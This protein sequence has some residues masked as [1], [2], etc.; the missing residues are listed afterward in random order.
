MQIATSSIFATAF[1]VFVPRFQKIKTEFLTL[2][3]LSEIDPNN[4][5]Q[6]AN[7]NINILGQP[8]SLSGDA[9]Y[10]GF[11]AYNNRPYSLMMGWP[12]N[13]SF[14]RCVL[15][16]CSSP[17]NYSKSKFQKNFCWKLRLVEIIGTKQKNSAFTNTI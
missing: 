8:H 15:I 3:R 6:K 4:N 12:I 11:A 13:Y 9:K 14:I 5:G 7:K 1:A 16:F 10:S 17:S 2:D